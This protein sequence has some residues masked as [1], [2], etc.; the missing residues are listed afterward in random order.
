MQSSALVAPGSGA[1]IQ[2]ASWRDLNSVRS[3]ERAC[4]PLDAWP[5]LD[6]L[7]VLTLPNVVRLKA[8]DGEN[9]VGFVAGDIRRGQRLA[10]IATICVHPDYQGRGIGS[11]LLRTCEEQMG[12]PRVKLSVRESNHTAIDLYRRNG[13]ADVGRWPRYYRGGEDGIVM[14]KVLN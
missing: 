11:A 8:L 6:M 10:W 5:L 9:I 4:F 13:Y 2:P 12:M 1:H 14:E 3:L 7:G